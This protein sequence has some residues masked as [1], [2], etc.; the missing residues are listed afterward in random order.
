MPIN[1][2][3]IT[4]TN[5]QRQV[6]DVREVLGDFLLAALCQGAHGSAVLLLAIF[7]H[8]FH[9]RLDNGDTSVHDVRCHN[10]VVMMASVAVV[11]ATN[12]HIPFTVI[13]YYVDDLHT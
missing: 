11:A 4:P 9:N 2:H 12:L 10:H 8:P 5:K 1:N 6:A 13:V 7:A 3:H